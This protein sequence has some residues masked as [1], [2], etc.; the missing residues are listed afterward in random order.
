MR[1]DSSRQD[2]FSSRVDHLPARQVSA[3][4]G[5]LPTIDCK[6]QIQDLRM[7]YKFPILYHKVME[8]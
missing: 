2:V 1:V 7:V 5:N 6:I 3:K 4:R 8:I